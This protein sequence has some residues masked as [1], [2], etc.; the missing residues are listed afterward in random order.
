V[1]SITLSGTLPRTTSSLSNQKTRR[2]PARASRISIADPRTPISPLCA[3]PLARCW[4]DHPSLL[5][6]KLTEAATAE[7]VATVAEATSAP[8][9][10]D[11]EQTDPNTEQAVTP[12]LAA[13]MAIP[14]TDPR[15]GKW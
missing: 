13:I 2:P 5:L 1:G 8:D 7:V 9:A 14:T 12:E 15:G 11:A 3:Q 6:R 10:I 4:L